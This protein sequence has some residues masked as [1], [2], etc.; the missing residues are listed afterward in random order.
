MWREASDVGQ[1]P[2]MTNAVTSSYCGM[3]WFSLSITET[4]QRVE[5]QGNKVTSVWLEGPSGGR[6]VRVLAGKPEDLCLIPKTHMVEELTPRCCPLTC[7]H[8]HT[9]SCRERDKTNLRFTVWELLSWTTDITQI[10]I[11]L[12]YVWDL[13]EASLSSRD[14]YSR[15]GM[16]SKG[17][18]Y[19]SLHGNRWDDVLFKF[20]PC[21][22]YAN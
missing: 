12:A 19:S 20:C 7:V 21:L 2:S 11:M 16:N 13:G 9:T 3:F 8:T 18:F 14:P 4:Q 10:V 1:P 22:F 17:A 15:L 6:A 5:K